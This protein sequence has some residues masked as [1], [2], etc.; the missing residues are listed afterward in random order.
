MKTG[1]PGIERSRSKGLEKREEKPGTEA[2]QPFSMA[3]A[4]FRM[5]NHRR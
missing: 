1:I 4:E 5:G 2:Y 3:E